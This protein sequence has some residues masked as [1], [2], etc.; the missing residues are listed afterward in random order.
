MSSDADTGSRTIYDVYCT[1]N[2]ALGVQ[3]S[4]T[5]Q[6]AL[7][8][9]YPSHSLISTTCDLIAYANAGH[10]IATLNEEVHPTLRSWDFQF[11]TREPLNGA[12]A[13]ELTQEV[14]FGKFDYVWQDQR[15]H[16]FV[17]DNGRC[18]RR[19][20]V[21]SPPAMTREEEKSHVD[22]KKAEALV[23][24]ANIWSESSH[25]NVWVFDYGRWIKDKKLWKI[26]HSVSWEDLIMDEGTKR[27]IFR[28][29]EGFFDAK[30]TYAELRAPW[31]VS[32]LAPLEF[33]Q[34]LLI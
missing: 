2:S 13:G 25:K 4:V 23:L 16:V 8:S 28:D 18:D 9:K 3:T 17:V 32:L 10:A 30:R 29:V 31:K 1:Q 33:E 21:L 19:Y 26:I 14:L 12:P 7:L 11:A 15:F 5:V 34:I 6:A 22:S 24:S 20:Y 27:S